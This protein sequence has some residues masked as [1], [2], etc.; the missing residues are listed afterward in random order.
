MK[1]ITDDT[2]RQVQRHLEEFGYTGLTFEFVKSKVDKLSAGESP[3][4]IIS[5]F[6]DY[7]LRKNGYLASPQAR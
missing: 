2:I 1:T 5:R 3:E 4:G 6:A 7:M